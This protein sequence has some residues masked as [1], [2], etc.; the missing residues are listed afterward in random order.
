MEELT[1]AYNIG[2]GPWDPSWNF[3]CLCGAEN[4]VGLIDSYK[5]DEG[6]GL[7]I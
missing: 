3:Q 2:F 6:Q 4:C 7:R 5:K 1:I